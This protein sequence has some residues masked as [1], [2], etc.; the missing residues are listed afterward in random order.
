LNSNLKAESLRVML[1]LVALL[2]D[3]AGWYSL[4]ASIAF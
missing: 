2:L 1:M 3:W 4:A